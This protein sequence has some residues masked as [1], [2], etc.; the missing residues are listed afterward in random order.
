MKLL[1]NFTT[2]AALLLLVSLA[3]SAQSRNAVTT[4]YNAVKDFSLKSNPNVVWSYGSLSAF[5]APLV[6]YT[7]PDTNCFPGLALSVWHGDGP[8]DTPYV[9]HN[10]S[11]QT[12]CFETICVPPQYLQ[13]DIGHSGAGPF[14]T[15]VRWT[16]PKSGAI[17]FYGEVEGLDWAG[18]T[19]TDLRVVYN[20]TTELL[21][22]VID[23]YESPV[24][25]RRQMA[26]S[27][28]D[29]IDF[30]VD[31]GQDG[32]WHCDSTGIQFTVSRVQ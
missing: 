2:A 19:T 22:V 17:T 5:G 25:F 30:L 4:D 23:S 12:I 29:T 9:A 3:A 27:A 26:V 1:K 18:P 32:D 14:I 13:L 24:T 10:D 7:T 21:R 6:L 15:V 28:G 31:M 8:C 16:A 11:S 20:T